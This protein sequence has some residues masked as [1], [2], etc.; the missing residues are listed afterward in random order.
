MGKQDPELE[1]GNRRAGQRPAVPRGSRSRDDLDPTPETAASCGASVHDYCEITVPQRGTERLEREN[2][3]A[4]VLTDEERRPRN[5][6]PTGLASTDPAA[7]LLAGSE[8]KLLSG[9]LVHTRKLSCIGALSLYLA[10]LTSCLVPG[11]LT[12]WRIGRLLQAS[13]VVTFTSCVLGLVLYAL[14]RPEGGGGD[15]RVAG[16]G[17]TALAASWGSSKSAGGGAS[18]SKGSSRSSC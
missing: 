1:R 7:Q 11:G 10:K 2:C 18:A 12:G 4:G 15:G 3:C 5:H 17:R 13:C 8:S 9:Q 6:R 14:G 16:R